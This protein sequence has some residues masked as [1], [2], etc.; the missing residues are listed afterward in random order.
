MNMF[1]VYREIGGPNIYIDRLSRL[2]NAQVVAAFPTR[3]EAV[4]FALGIVDENESVLISKGIEGSVVVVERTFSMQN[5]DDNNLISECD[6][7]MIM[8]PSNPEEPEIF[9]LEGEINIVGQ[10]IVGETLILESDNLNTSGPF[11]YQWW[12]RDAIEEPFYKIPSAIADYHILTVNDLGKEIRVTMEKDGWEGTLTSNITNPI[13]DIEPIILPELVGEV[14]ID[15]SLQVGE[16][17]TADT[18]ELE[19]TGEIDY[20]WLRTDSASSTVFNL[21]L[22]ANGSTYTLDIDDENQYIALSVGRQGYEGRIQSDSFG[23][24]VGV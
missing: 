11:Q 19:G 12:R 6:W 1:F 5:G 24:V 2:V 14:Q 4:D 8:N 20:Q 7:E 16:I 10:P 22:G 3:R 17:L 18:I 15:G 9:T 23:P 13:S 21:I